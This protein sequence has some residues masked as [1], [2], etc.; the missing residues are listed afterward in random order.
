[1]EPIK[2]FEKPSAETSLPSQSPKQKGFIRKSLDAI[3]NVF[4]RQ[5]KKR[6]NAA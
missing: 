4:A 1:V 5:G 3:Q 2:D 6:K